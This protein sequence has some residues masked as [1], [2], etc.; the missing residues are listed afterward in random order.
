MFC[1]TK[2]RKELWFTFVCF[3]TFFHPYTVD[4][5]FINLFFFLKIEI[6]GLIVSFYSNISFYLIKCYSPN[7]C[8]IFLNADQRLDILYF[9]ITFDKM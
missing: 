9:Y 6:P 1:S 4:K 5:I 2:A 7:F 8:F 3:M